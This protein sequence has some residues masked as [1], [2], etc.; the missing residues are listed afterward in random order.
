MELS[1]LD[2][3]VASE[4]AFGPDPY[5]GLMPWDTELVLFLDAGLDI[6]VA[7]MAEGRTNFSH[8]LVADWSEAEDFA[9]RADFPAHWLILRPAGENDPRIRKGIADWAALHE[10]FLLARAEAANGR[11]FIETDMRAHANPTRMAL[12]ARAVEDL[13]ARLRAA[14]PACGSP[15]YRLL[16][17]VPGLPCEDCGM[18]TRETRV[19]I[20]GCERCGQRERRERAGHARAPAGRCDYCNP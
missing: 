2:L 3:G 14:C 13:L 18:P 8:R 7:G 12:I 19:E 11:A 17:R 5:T 1:G 9:R 15:G 20:L 4:G 10:T 16:E 6:Q